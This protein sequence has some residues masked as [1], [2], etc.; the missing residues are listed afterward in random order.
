MLNSSSTWRRIVLRVFYLGSRSSSTRLDIRPQA[1]EVSRFLG[2]DKVMMASVI[3][4]GVD[5]RVLIGSKL[6]MLGTDADMPMPILLRFLPPYACLRTVGFPKDHYA[7]QPSR[8]LPLPR[9]V[10]I[11]LA[12]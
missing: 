3:R 2:L 11:W 8:M 5:D 7:Q 9:T 6:Q 12:S 1:V 10:L 4:V